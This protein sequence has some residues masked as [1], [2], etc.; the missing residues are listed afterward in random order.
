M[1]RWAVYVDGVPVLKRDG[2]IALYVYNLN[3]LGRHL[4]AVIR[5]SGLRTCGSLGCRPEAST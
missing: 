3:A 2:L 1:W 5:K 4:V